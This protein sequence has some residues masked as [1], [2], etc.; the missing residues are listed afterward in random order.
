MSGN[1]TQAMPDDPRNRPY[2]DEELRQLAT[3]DKTLVGPRREGVKQDA[4]PFKPTLWLVQGA[5]AKPQTLDSTKVVFS[6]GSSRDEASFQIFD[7]AISH[8]QLCLIFL[9]SDWL[10]VDC[11]IKDV[12][13]FDGVPGRQIVAP[14]HSR[15]VIGLGDAYAIFDA[16]N[17]EESGKEFEALPKRRRLHDDVLD[18]HAPAEMRVTGERHQAKS[19]RDPILIG[20]HNECDVVVSGEHIRP[21]HAMLYWHPDGVFARPLGRHQI[22]VNDQAADGGCPLSKGENKLR[23]NDVELPIMVAGDVDKACT[24]MFPQDRL[25]FDSFCLSNLEWSTN[26]SFTISS[27]GGAVTV[28]R[29]KACNIVPLDTGISRVHAQ[30]IPSGKS[31]YLIDNYSSNGTFVNG[32]RITKSRCHAGDI[33]EVGSSFFIVHYV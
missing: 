31:F 26:E 25:H 12:V 11:G 2:T 17:P 9:G 30:I 8:K 24:Q 14:W 6:L 28:G 27:F 18:H 10:I 32:V 16:H 5:A 22:E 20:S 23:L 13:S 15:T 33:V 21:F 19:R 1:D 3:G 29:S 7:P 4:T